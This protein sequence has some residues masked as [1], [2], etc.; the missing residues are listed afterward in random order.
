MLNSCSILLFDS[1]KEG[2]KVEINKHGISK[3]LNSCS[4]RFLSSAKVGI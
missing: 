4:C 3:I 1:I 2:Q